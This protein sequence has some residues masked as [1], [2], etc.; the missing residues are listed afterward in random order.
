MAIYRVVGSVSLAQ[1]I[2]DRAH[3][4]PFAAFNRL[5]FEKKNVPIHCCRVATVREKYL[6][7]EIFFLSGKSQGISWMAREI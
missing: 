4:F 1:Y 2:K 6:E 7:N 3:S 5:S